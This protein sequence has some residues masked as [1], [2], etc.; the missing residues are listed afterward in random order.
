VLYTFFT[1]FFYYS[2]VFLIAASVAQ[3]YYGN[4]SN[5]E[6]SMLGT[7]FKWYFKSSI[8]PITFAAVVITIIKII[9]TL[10]S[11]NSSNPVLRLCFCIIKCIFAALEYMIKIM[12]HYAIIGMAF[13][14][15]GY[16]TSAKRAGVL[17]FSNLGLFATVDIIQS[18][19]FYVSLLICMGIPTAVGAIITVNQIIPLYTYMELAVNGQVLLFYMI[20]LV[21]ILSLICSIIFVSTFTEALGAVFVFY[22]MD[23]E[24]ARMGVM[25]H[26]APDGVKQLLDEISR[27]EM[28]QTEGPTQMVLP[29]ASFEVLPGQQQIY[30]SNKAL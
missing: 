20:G 9:R 23:K 1:Y 27:A 17:I 8:G 28:A 4:L 6:N 5:I 12:N 29:D 16:Y 22:C 11:E 18:F 24:L 7:A 14:G 10:V 15:E 2:M 21:L 26:N 30:P 13:T 3:W 25:Q 19:F